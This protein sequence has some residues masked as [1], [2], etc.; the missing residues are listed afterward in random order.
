MTARG[1]ERPHRACRSS[2]RRRTPGPSGENPLCR[3][4]ER[5][6]TVTGARW[7]D[8]TSQAPSTG[9]LPPAGRPADG[10][11][12]G[13][14]LH[15]VAFYTTPCTRSPSLRGTAL[16]RPPGEAQRLV[17]P[18]HSAPRSGC[19]R[20]G[21]RAPVGARTETPRRPRSRPHDRL[22]RVRYGELCQLAERSAR[23]QQLSVVVRA[24]RR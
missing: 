21:P 18:G 8:G 12:P 16:G 13:D 19:I 4:A 14:A 24:R 17:T 3:R 2:A 10:G 1:C 5:Y 20:S 9:V 7:R 23:E 15:S 22:S 11:D 6:S